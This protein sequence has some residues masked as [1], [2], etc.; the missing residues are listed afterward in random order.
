[1]SYNKGFLVTL[2]GDKP[3][4]ESAFKNIVKVKDNAQ[5]TVISRLEKL[6]ERYFSQNI[7]ISRLNLA[8]IRNMKTQL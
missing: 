3:F 2:H 1:M 4:E 8:T 6:L 5:I 7:G